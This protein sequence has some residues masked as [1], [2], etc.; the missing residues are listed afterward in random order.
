MLDGITLLSIGILIDFSS[1]RA[2]SK[3]KGGWNQARVER[4][5]DRGMVSKWRAREAMSHDGGHRRTER[6][7]WLDLEFRVSRELGRLNDN[8]LRFLWCDGFIP[9]DHQV[10]S[11]AIVGR[12]LISEDDGHTFTDYRFTLILSS[13]TA[14]NHRFDLSALLPSDA[15]NWLFV[16]RDQKQIEIRCP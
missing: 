8:Q 1:S 11:R 3:L 6:E 14:Q 7:F 13:Q 12:A 2:P 16:D 10:D 4:L 15:R 5:A 9:D